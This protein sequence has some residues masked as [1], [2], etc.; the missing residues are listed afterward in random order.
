[1]PDSIP[2]EWDE[3]T[4]DACVWKLNLTSCQTSSKTA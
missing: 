3:M 4:W 1:M 2:S